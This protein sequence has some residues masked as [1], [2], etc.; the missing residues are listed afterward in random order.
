M[1]GDTRGARKGDSPGGQEA[2]V[3]W[4]SV[5]GV[6]LG[7]QRVVL[8]AVWRGAQKEGEEDLHCICPL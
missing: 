4:L 6:P 3:R 2:P 7:P 1:A 5:V 8:V